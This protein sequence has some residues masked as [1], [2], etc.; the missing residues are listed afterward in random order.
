[1]K[2]TEQKILI[3]DDHGV[4]RLGLSLII[5]KQRPN[6]YVKE[7]DNYQKVLESIYEECFDLII[8]DIN[9]PD[10]NFQDTLQRIKSNCS[11]T[12]VLVFSSQDESLYAI[13]YLKMGADGFLH[14]LANDDTI[15]KALIKM[16]DKGSYMSEDVKDAL[17]FNKLTN[18]STVNPLEVLTDREIEVAEVLIKGKPLKD[19]ANNLNIHVSTVSTY[20]TRIFDKLN[21]NSLPQLI[22]IFD[23]YKIAKD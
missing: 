18:Q 4:V 17:I 13:R 11:S 23:L 19:I 14:K 5:K 3:A 2:Q 1:M 15:K 12:K 21:I 7:V 6:A 10:G 22:K 20:K 16:L 8:L 9:M